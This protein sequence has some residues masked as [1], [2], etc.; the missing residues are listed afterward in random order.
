M[1]YSD[2]NAK[3]Y[4]AQK[5][6]FGIP[7]K[8]AQ[9]VLKE[10]LAQSRDNDSPEEIFKE[11]FKL[12]ADNNEDIMHLSRDIISLLY[13]IVEEMSQGNAVRIQPLHAMMST[14]EAAAYLNV[15]RPYLIKLLKQGVLPHEKVGTH[16]RVKYEDVSRYKKEQREKALQNMDELAKMAYED[17]QGY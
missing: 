9:K 10:L 17:R 2:R 15:S 1:T 7:N 13:R 5:D 8:S 3:G 12:K 6:E 16:R 14:Q 4:D 11:L